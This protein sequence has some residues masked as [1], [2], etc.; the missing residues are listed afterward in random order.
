VQPAPRHKPLSALSA[1]AGDAILRPVD[2]G[3]VLDLSG[4]ALSKVPSATDVADSLRSLLLTG[5]ALVTLDGLPTMSSLSRLDLSFNRLTSLSHF[6]PLPALATLNASCNNI[7]PVDDIN[8]LRKHASLITSLDLRINRITFH[9]TYHTLTLRRLP[10]LCA[11]DGTPVTTAMR[12]HARAAGA[13]IPTSVLH[14]AC[15]FPAP[16][17]ALDRGP[18]FSSKGDLVKEAGVPG[19][20]AALAVGITLEGQH[21]RRLAGVRSFKALRWASFA[22]N[23]LSSFDG[24]QGFSCLTRLD[25]SVRCPWTQP[26]RL[27]VSEGVYCAGAVLRLGLSPS[28]RRKVLYWAGAS[29]IIPSPSKLCA[30]CWLSQALIVHTLVDLMT[31]LMP[32]VTPVSL[33]AAEACLAVG[34]DMPPELPASEHQSLCHERGRCLQQNLLVSAHGVSALRHLRHL[35]VHANRLS[36]V[37]TISTLSL[38]THLCIESNNID[39]LSGVGP[40]LHLVELYA[41]GNRLRC[42]RSVAPLQF[43]SKLLILDLQVRA[44]YT[45]LRV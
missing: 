16:A 4:Y 11:L 39:S 26:V 45:P 25:L 38:L 36:S 30:H 1:A 35:D 7:T 2:G 6:P 28:L 44:K 34:T 42:L 27:F 20:S 10:H 9:K 32:S 21:L 14:A 40:L 31:V 18:S 19:V 37:A 29:G 12:Q 41:A 3:A 43:L 15:T 33:G 23:E 22:D 24:L 13:A 17:M 8:L 5:N